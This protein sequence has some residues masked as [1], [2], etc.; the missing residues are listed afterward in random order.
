MTVYPG[1]LG[2]ILARV[3]SSASAGRRP[4]VVF[5]LDSTLID[6]S[7]RHLAILRAFAL[8]NGGRELQQ[9]VGAL[10]PSDMGYRVEEPLVRA[11]LRDP[12]LLAHLHAFWWERFFSDAWCAADLPTPGAVGYVRAVVERGGLAWYLTARPAQEMGRG[13]LEALLRTGFPVMD[14]CSVLHLRTEVGQSDHRFK[15]EA[16]A[17]VLAHGEVVAT[18]EN[19]P[20]HVH[21]FAD[22]I[23]GAVHV[24]LDTVH[25]PTAP[26]LRDGVPRIRDFQPT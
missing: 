18:F 3:V 10:R 20:A 7:H 9:V 24:L 1:V 12:D 15:A 6:T 26:P 21:G 17:R 25:S 23:P 13:T 11:G 2:E 14:G 4:V 5:D 8:Q 19:E 22:R 16:V